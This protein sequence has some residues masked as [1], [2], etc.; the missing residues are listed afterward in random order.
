MNIHKILANAP[1]GATHYY[2]GF[3]ATSYYKKDKDDLLFRKYLSDGC[4]T[5]SFIDTAKPKSLKKLRKL[6]D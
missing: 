2:C 4:L 6:L 3:F 5:V 1:K